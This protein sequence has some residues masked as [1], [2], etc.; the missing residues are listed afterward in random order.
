MGLFRSKKAG[1]FKCE[2]PHLAEVQRQDSNRKLIA[3]AQLVTNMTP[4][5]S[6]FLSTDTTVLPH[7]ELEVM[8]YEDSG[9]AQATRRSPAGN[10]AT[11]LHCRNSSCLGPVCSRHS[12]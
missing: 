6:F 3:R 8:S 4:Q 11:A 10:D 9:T 5:P 2:R 7:D 12:A 1:R